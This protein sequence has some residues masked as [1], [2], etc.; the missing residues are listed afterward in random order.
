[1]IKCLSFFIVPYRSS[2]TPFY[3]PKWCELGSVPQLFTFPMFHLK[4]SSDVSPQ[5]HI[6]IYQGAW[7]CIKIFL[8][9]NS[10]LLPQ[11]FLPPFTNSMWEFFRVLELEFLI[12]TFEKVL[13]LPPS[14]GRKMKPSRCSTRGFRC[15]KRLPMLKEDIQSIT[16]LEAAHRYF[17]S[18][19]GI[20]TLHA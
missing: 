5:I 18:L 15:S 1:V 8:L 7:E 14:L 4:F 17:R 12:K 19:E 6:R 16:E 11:T 3:P 10:L 13:Q 2:S 9:N 20:S